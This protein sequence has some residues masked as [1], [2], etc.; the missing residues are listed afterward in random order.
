MRKVG[1]KYL[2]A[3]VVLILLAILVFL[4]SGAGPGALPREMGFFGALHNSLWNLD[5]AKWK[6]RKSI[7]PKAMFLQ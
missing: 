2:A 6:W 7:R 5:L 1:Y 4:P 3:A